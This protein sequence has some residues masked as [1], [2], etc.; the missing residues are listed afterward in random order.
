MVSPWKKSTG[1]TKMK[2]IKS[3]I[4]LQLTVFISVILLFF[5]LIFGILNR[6]AGKMLK[7]NTERMNETILSQIDGKI[8]DYY[9]FT[10]RVG[11]SFAY[12]PSVYDYFTQS[13]RERI[14]SAGALS[15]VEVNTTLLEDNILG[16]YL[17]D[18]DMNKIADM[19]RGENDP[20][21]ENGL[22]E[23]MEFSDIIL[24]EQGIVPYYMVSFPVYN[25][26]SSRYGEQIGMCVFYMKLN[27]FASFL[28]NTQATEHTEV[29]LL[30]GNNYIVS[31]KGGADFTYLSSEMQVSGN[32]YYVQTRDLKIQGW[33]IV[34]RI[35][36]DELYSSTENIHMYIGILSGAMLLFMSCFIYFCYRHMVLPLRHVDQSI[37]KMAVHPEERIYIEREDE[38][39]N[40]AA[41][42]NHMLDEKERLNQE[43]QESQR[44]IYETEL[45]K[46]QL[47]ILAYRNQIN[48]HFL[49]NTFDCIRAMALYYDVDCIA[50]ITVAL[51]HVFRF[52][53]KGS[54]IVALEEEIRY[55][56]E[57]GKIISFRFNGK[58]KIN[59][60][61]DET[62]LQ[63]RVIKMMLQ[64]LVENA[65]IHGMENKV[66][67]GNIDVMI[68]PRPENRL[69]FVVKDDGCGMSEE[70][71]QEILS[72]LEKKQEENGVGINNIYQRLLLFYGE[73]VRFTMNSEDGKGTEISIEIPDTVEERGTNHDYNLSGR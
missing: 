70:R 2:K 60:N 39:G 46:K 23:K 4:F 5:L 53:V 37:Q 7:E 58:I 29:Y 1:R 65:V 54:N 52:A 56:R 48:P 43:I 72:S 61:V 15:D 66:G 27:D 71:L 36:E 25:L 47:Q 35:P 14:M 68:Q 16:I 31:R 63:K 24:P 28:N 12:S 32:Q 69:L 42:L 38:I 73:E 55:I 59:L 33:K 62:I 44:K 51:S 8:D 13:F 20:R 22:I 64:P 3:S 17:Y 40:V 57:Y 9:D 19:G 21:L 41:S 18:K 34:S 45:A 50:D 6:N 30:D 67:G 49:Y 10:N 11:I 26:E